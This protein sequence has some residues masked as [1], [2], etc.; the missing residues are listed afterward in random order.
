MQLNVR[1]CSGLAD[2]KCE[3]V[4]YLT[5]PLEHMSQ[6]TLN[7]WLR[8]FDFEVAKQNGERYL[9]NSLYSLICAINRLSSE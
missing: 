6:N 9:P 2:L 3:D 1:G 5:V 4:Q 8:K 7:V